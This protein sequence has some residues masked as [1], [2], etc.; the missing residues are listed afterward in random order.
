MYSNSG[1]CHIANARPSHVWKKH[2]Q[3]QNITRALEI[4]AVRRRGHTQRT[5][6]GPV[7]VKSRAVAR[8]KPIRGAYFAI[9]AL[10][11]AGFAGSGAGA[12]GAG[13]AGVGTAGAGLVDAGAVG[14]S[15]V[16]G[17]GP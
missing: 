9:G 6:A 8:D 14:V 4:A 3:N 12:A 16:D 2:D 17:A 13:V 5:T 1:N 10:G 15:W 11:S 7:V